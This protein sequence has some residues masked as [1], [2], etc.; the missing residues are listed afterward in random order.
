MA[1]LIFEGST[2][3]DVVQ[4]VRAWLADIED[5]DVLV[6]TVVDEPPADG[7]LFERESFDE[8]SDALRDLLRSLRRIAPGVVEDEAQ[9]LSLLARISGFG[10]ASRVDAD[11]PTSM[12]NVLQWLVETAQKANA[13]SDPGAG[14]ERSD[15]GAEDDSEDW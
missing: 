5:Q 1:K 3:A 7:R 13:G 12:S 11:P 4:Q 10:S 9:L 6:G 2:H 15:A 14:S 8:R